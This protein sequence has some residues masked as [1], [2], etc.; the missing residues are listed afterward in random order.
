MSDTQG[1]LSGEGIDK[2]FK[3]MIL[4]VTKQVED[5]QKVLG[6]PD[7]QLIAK[8]E[9][10]D[11]YIDNLKGVIESKCYY[12]N[13]NHQNLD[14]RALDLIRAVNIISNN[15][16]RIGD[17][18]VSI[19]SQLDYLDDPKFIQHL[20]YEEFF[21]ETLQGLQWIGR[22]LKKQDVNLA[23]KI[24]RIE[25][26][27]DVLF[28]KNLKLI[29]S[30]LKL[31]ENTE[32]LVTLLFIAKYLE[33]MGDAILN[34]GEAVILAALGEKLKIHDFEAL[35]DSIDGQKNMD[36]IA[37]LSI[38]S[39][40]ET[41]SGCR[42]SR[43]ENQKKKKEDKSRVIFKE[44]RI[45]KLKKEYE[46][47]L[48]WEEIQPGLTP[49]VFNYHQNGKN[50]SI[51]LEFLN[52][53]TIQQAIWDP[54]SGFLNEALS[55]LKRTMTKIWEQTKKES[56]VNA[57]FL[58]QLRS[59]LDDIFKV[60]MEFKVHE[61]QIGSVCSLSL[62]DL[63]IVGSELEKNLA[64]PFSVRIHGD[65]N[66]DNVLY[67][68]GEKRIHFIDLYRSDN[69]DYVQDLSVFLASNFRQPIFAPSI[70]T[71]LDRVIADFFDFGKKFARKNNDDTYEARM[72]LGMARSFLTSTRFEFNND[73]AEAMRL[74][75]V[76]LLE[77]VVGHEGN[78]WSEFKFPEEVLYY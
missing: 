63:L 10:R 55:E 50:A 31:E 46:N 32:N 12:S 18:A 8:I 56:P 68:L 51:L 45:K 39:I 64:A 47:I 16:E 14:K 36:P 77:K 11:D 78:P 53:K 20:E 49:K 15:L 17:Y 24:C 42:I 72:A 25:F 66:I 27:I 43:V 62:K 29:I 22:A 61:M 57:H 33:R 69:Q 28:K 40:W 60:H 30:G 23:L 34:I 76:Y 1:I 21:D 19:V 2:N 7:P 73:F 54:K 59:R 6:K 67:D 13:L 41:R 65:F 4:E 37:S 5:T 35:E 38:E 58:K 74:R 44:G 71:R 26:N 70:R 48:S 9:A 52:G 75:S 3:F